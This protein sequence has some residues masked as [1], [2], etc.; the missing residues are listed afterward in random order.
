MGI[1]FFS[2]ISPQQCLDTLL[3]QNLLFATIIDGEQVF[4][5]SKKFT[6]QKGVIPVVNRKCRKQK[7]LMLEKQD[8]EIIVWFYNSNH[9]LKCDIVSSP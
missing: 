8:N 3:E 1:V 7:F 5:I 9:K 6:S 4:R 2:D